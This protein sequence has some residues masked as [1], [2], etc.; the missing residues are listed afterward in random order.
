MRRSW[1]KRAKRI[2]GGIHVCADRPFTSRRSDSQPMILKDKFRSEVSAVLN[3]FTVCL[4]CLI[5]GRVRNLIPTRGSRQIT[6][7][8]QSLTLLASGFKQLVV[9]SAS[10][11][12]DSELELQSRLEFCERSHS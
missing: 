7:W 2:G 12:V 8:V 9:V 11:S 6:V 5:D 4:P 3:G 10:T 1:A